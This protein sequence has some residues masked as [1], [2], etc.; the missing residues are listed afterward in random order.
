MQSVSTLSC[1]SLTPWSC[2]EFAA[3]LS[4]SLGLN[5]DQ[6]EMLL[7]LLAES[8]D[9][10]RCRAQPLL[11][12]CV[13]AR[14]LSILAYPAESGSTLASSLDCFHE[15]GRFHEVVA[16]W[17]GCSGPSQGGCRRCHFTVHLQ[18]WGSDLYF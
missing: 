11:V 17:A 9:R 18:G 6:T 14:E 12:G 15:P 10:R 13:L 4:R 16:P 1:P 8:P 7:S 3:I 2:G 5:G